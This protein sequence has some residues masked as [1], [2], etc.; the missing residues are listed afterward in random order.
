MN[1]SW[2]RLYDDLFFFRIEFDMYIWKYTGRP[3]TY[4]I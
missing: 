2:K 3:G 4:G 1:I